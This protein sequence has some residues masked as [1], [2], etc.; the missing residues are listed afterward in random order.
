VV[1][2]VVVDFFLLV[3]KVLRLALFRRFLQ[4]HPNNLD[5]DLFIKNVQKKLYK[6]TKKFIFI[7]KTFYITH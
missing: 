7:L 5:E 3:V 1:W 6:R 4:D 2:V